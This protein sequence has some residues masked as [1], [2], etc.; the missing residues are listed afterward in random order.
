M[1][2]ASVTSTGP[3]NSSALTVLLIVTLPVL[4][5]ISMPVPA[6]IWVTPGS[7]RSTVTV[8]PVA[9]LALNDATSVPP[10]SLTDSTPS[11]GALGTT[12][13]G[14]EMVVSP[15]WLTVKE[16]ISVASAF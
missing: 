6:V 7:G 14:N 8:E 3:A 10:A 11:P 15:D 2:L 1:V 5:S 12:S 13:A 16:P 4:V 9:W